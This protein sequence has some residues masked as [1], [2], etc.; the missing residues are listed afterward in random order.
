MRSV[1]RRW[2]AI[3]SRILGWNEAIREV[4]HDYIEYLRQYEAICVVVRDFV[5]YLRKYEAIRRTAHCCVF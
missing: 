5:E 2:C 3:S 4:V 1:R